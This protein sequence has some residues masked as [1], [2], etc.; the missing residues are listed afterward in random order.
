MNGYFERLRTKSYNRTKSAFHKAMGER[1]L[2]ERKN[3]QEDR[4]ESK[5]RHL[6]QSQENKNGKKERKVKNDYG[7]GK[8]VFIALTIT[9]C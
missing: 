1:Q 2:I 5:A 7:E 9:R 4:G 8:N 6:G 3:R